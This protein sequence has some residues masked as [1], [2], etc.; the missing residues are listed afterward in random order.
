MIY[1]ALEAWALRRHSNKSK[2]WIYRKYF[3]RRGFS[4]WNFYANIKDKEGD[5]AQLF[6]YK[7]SKTPIRRHIKIKSSA[8]PYNPEFKEYFEQ[9]NNMSNTRKSCNDYGRLKDY[10]MLGDNVALFRA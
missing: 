3:I 8:T 9:R 1:K 6:L 7:A 5:V 4:N 10:K 2:S